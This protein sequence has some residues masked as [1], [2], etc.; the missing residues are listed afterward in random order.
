M[1]G[2]IGVVRRRSTRVPPE[3]AALSA[4]VVA[5][6]ERVSGWTRGVE[7]LLAAAAALEGVDLQLRGVP[8]VRALLGDRAGALAIEHHTTELTATLA[9]REAQL[10]AGELEV[11]VTELEAVNAAL[12]RAKDAAWAVHN[13]RL[14]TA[15]AV[16]DLAGADA[17]VAAIEAF[18]SVQ[19]AR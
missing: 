4:E 19:V 10:D 3:L 2:I 11:D 17:G 9:A 1:C 15:R 13:D 8:G 5:A 18:T 7:D 6:F 14:R 12:L 16:G